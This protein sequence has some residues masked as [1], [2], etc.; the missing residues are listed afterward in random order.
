[1]SNHIPRE[2]IDHLI[3]RSDI[4]DIIQE[5]V[6][7]K[8]AGKNFV[9]CC[10]FHQEKTPSFNV[11]QVKQFYHC[12]GCGVSGNVISFLMDYDRLGFIDAIE[13]LAKRAG[14]EV[15][16]EKSIDPKQQQSKLE[17]VGLMENIAAFYQQQLKASPQ[18]IEYLKSR[19]IS[20][21]TAKQFSIGYA[22]DSW[23]SVL[24]QFK[25]AEKLLSLGMVI[26]KDNQQGFYDRFRNRLMFPIHNTRGQVIG[27]GGRVMDQSLPKYLNSPETSL[28]QK[29]H[30]LYGWHQ[31][32]QSTRKLEQVFVVE[33]YLDVISLHQAGITEA[34]ATLG[35]AT[36]SE[37][38]NKIARQCAHIIFCFDGDKAGRD[39][40]WRA[41]NNALPALQDG[42]QL[43]FLFLP[44]G[45]D[46]DS[47]VQKQG[48]AAF[49]EFAKQA[50]PLSEYLFKQLSVDCNLQQAEGRSKLVKSAIPLL[51]KIPQGAFLRML[52]EALANMTKFDLSS[53]QRLLQDAQ[54][55]PAEQFEVLAN[56][57]TNQYRLQLTPM[58][59][60]IAL[61]VQHPSC[62]QSADAEKIHNLTQKL[63]GAELLEKVF[64]ACIEKPEASTATLLEAWR[65]LPEFSHLLKLAA[66]ELE[67]NDEKTLQATW[68]DSLQRLEQ[69]AKHIEITALLEKMK[70]NGLNEIENA[71]LLALIA[72]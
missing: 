34:V 33:G 66:L 49:R 45:E 10:P 16:R 8:K 6:Q 13:F 60:A 7:L 47:F 69:Q 32:L 58:R 39:A 41:L 57:V 51:A 68:Q 61:L 22:P 26:E 18:A 53:M 36:S 35:T 29:S 64:L 3:A 12:F 11:S 17:D 28:F 59:L 50:L 71:R 21:T 70:A 46:P 1:M 15:P 2:F 44:E 54:Q 23:D 72:S 65:N 9:A 25:H 31:A 14:V 40:A 67:I 27:F 38:V 56:R 5:R 42:L 55:K 30:E 20:G 37:H 48:A 24:K 62:A 63:P 4:V 19:A 52:C 43:D